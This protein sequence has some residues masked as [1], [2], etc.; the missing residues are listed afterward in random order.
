[1]Y[2]NV[3]RE[4]RPN[5]L[6]QLICCWLDHL[7]KFMKDGFCDHWP[8]FEQVKIKRYYW[9]TFADNF[10]AD[11]SDFLPSSAYAGTRSRSSAGS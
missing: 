6:R 8:Q 5:V 3:A 10:A 9:A 11:Q 4:D 2:V 1:M 7:R